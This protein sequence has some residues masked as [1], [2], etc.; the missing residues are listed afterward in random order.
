MY[1][2]DE[3]LFH[4][5]EVELVQL[6]SVAFARMLERDKVLFDKTQPQERCFMHRFAQELRLVF[7]FA[8]NYRKNGSPILS[9]DV[10][11]NR[12]GNGKKTPDGDAEASKKKWIAPDIILHERGSKEYE[13]RNDIFACEMKKDALPDKTDAERLSNEFLGR[14]KYKFGIDF[15]QCAKSPYMFSLYTQGQPSPQGYYFNE[16]DNKF[17]KED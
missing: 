3:G 14:R 2:D 1:F 8:E 12:D 15:Y 4:I 10:E 11:Y 6:F 13:F 5:D 7:T 17:K 16:K 9:L